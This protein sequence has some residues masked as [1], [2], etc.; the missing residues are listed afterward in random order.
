M[1]RE[2]RRRPAIPRW[3][4]ARGAGSARRAVHLTALLLLVVLTGPVALIGA[5]STMVVALGSAALW[6][7]APVV[8]IVLVLA[9]QRSAL[10][11]AEPDEGPEPDPDAWAEG[12]AVLPPRS[13]RLL[14]LVR[15]PGAERSRLRAAAEAEHLGR[16][17]VPLL[18]AAVAMLG[19]V[20]TLTWVAL[21][22]LVAEADPAEPERLIAL[23]QAVMLTLPAS[24]VLLGIVV[25]TADRAR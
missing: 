16:L 7:L 21:P 13:R 10:A 18:M 4:A 19:G 8:L 17:I 12:R 11:L 15:D 25:A 6:P 14:G 22:D 9:W 3:P 23:A 1:D 24:G 5:G 2:R 20:F